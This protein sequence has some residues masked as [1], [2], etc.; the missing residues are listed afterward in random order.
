MAY[1]NREL[2]AR[3]IQCEAGGEGDN[4]MR[5][6]ASVVINRARQT[7]GEYARISQGG[8]IRNIIFQRGQ[9]DCASETLGGGYNA[10]NIYK[11]RPEA[12]HYAIADWALAGKSLYGIGE[13][14]WF[15][16]PYAQPCRPSFP[17]TVG[18][19]INKIG[20]HCFYQPTASYYST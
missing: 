9:F 18:A 16:N 8:N 13:A 5:A 10:Q 6:V 1:S 14:L 11:M 3:L 19:F 7:S 17:S 4:G 20:Q 15:Y 12:I 2:L